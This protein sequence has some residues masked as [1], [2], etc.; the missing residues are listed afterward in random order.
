MSKVT[1]R[2]LDIMDLPFL[3]EVESHPEVVQYH[4]ADTPVPSADDL[5]AYIE[6][7]GDFD[8]D[9]QIR[10]VICSDTRPV[11]FIDLFDADFN[12]QLAHVGIIIDSPFRSQGKGYL[13]LKLLMDKAREWGLKSLK[14]EVYTHNQASYRL[15]TKSG[16]KE[17]SRSDS[18]V[19]LAYK[20]D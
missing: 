9:L 16:F 20:L 11:G 4:L 7:E 17:I 13:A 8:T 1:L 15:F 6:R 2:R 3:V 10:Y 12:A 5:A 18:S 19:C 14:A